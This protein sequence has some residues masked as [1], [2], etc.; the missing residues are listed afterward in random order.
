MGTTL[1]NIIAHNGYAVR[2]WNYEGDPDPLIQ[3]RDSRE[4]KKYLPGIKLSANIIPEPNLEKA[5]TNARVIFLAVP[6]GIIISLVER[7]VDLPHSSLLLSGRGKMM[8]P[9]V[10]VSKGFREMDF[11]NH[12][13]VPEKIRK[14]FKDMVII[15]GPAVAADLAKGGFTAMNIAARNPQS[16][17]LV[18]KV[19]ENEYVKLLPTTDVI[20]IK[21][22][23]A[24]KNVYAILLGMCDGLGFTL[25]TKAFLLTEA[26]A[27]IEKLCIKLG[28]K[29]LS[30]VSLSGLGDLIGTGLNIASRNRRFGEF[31]IRANSKEEAEREVGQV[32]EG[33]RACKMARRL[34]QRY[35]IKA[36]LIELIYKIIEQRKN[37]QQ[38]IEL[39]LK[40]FKT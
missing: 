9:V 25:N 30:V 18:K 2:L 8:V 39:F 23:G 19:L 34:V 17:K 29:A 37:P 12:I 31:M 35:R 16:S 22:C 1:A 11:D 33:I 38:E 20:G 40:K 26:V 28:G 24:M 15:S 3:I 36:P 32:V 13:K 21:L 7:L 4:N 5:V 14:I 27:E 10:D 6:S